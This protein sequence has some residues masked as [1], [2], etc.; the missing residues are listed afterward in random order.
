MVVRNLKCL[1]L[2]NATPT[3]KEM[4]GTN[5]GSI[6]RRSMETLY[7]KITN[8]HS[9][10]LFN[11]EKVTAYIEETL[12]SDIYITKLTRGMNGFTFANVL[13]QCTWP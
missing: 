4:R 2:S 10:N 6:F 11:L 5:D 8:K 1:S 12:V 3:K 9:Q 13:N 7:Q